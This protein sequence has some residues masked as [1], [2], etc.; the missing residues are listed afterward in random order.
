MPYMLILI[1]ALFLAAPV[2]G[3]EATV[4]GP[5]KVLRQPVLMENSAYPLLSVTFNHSSHKEFKCRSCHHMETDDGNRFAPC[6][7]DGCHDLKGPRE[8]DPMSMFM[9]YHAPDSKRSC[10]GCHRQYAGKYP[11]FQGCRPCHMSNQ[12]EKAA[13]EAK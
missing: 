10:Y 9:A 1:F 11:D 3:Q 8:R 13:L 2:F 12:A 6:T 4:Q 7:T 5:L